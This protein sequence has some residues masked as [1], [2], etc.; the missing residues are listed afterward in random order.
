MGEG[1]TRF[2]ALAELVRRRT[3]SGRR[4]SFSLRMGSLAE[5]PGKECPVAQLWFHRHA[6]SE[7][8]GRSSAG[9]REGLSDTAPRCLHVLGR[10][11]LEGRRRKLGKEKER[12]LLRKVAPPSGPGKEDPLPPFEQRRALQRRRAPVA[13]GLRSRAAPSL[14]ATSRAARSPFGLAIPFPAM[15]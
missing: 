11:P 5:L 1:E 8:P 9:S 2:K 10:H 3:Q 14:R 7:K 6:G 15:S 13:P 12:S 4:R